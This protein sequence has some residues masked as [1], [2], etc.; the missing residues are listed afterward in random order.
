V[1]EAAYR[2]IR[3]YERRRGAIPGCVV[4]PELVA[5]ALG[6]SV[7]YFS[8]E[9]REDHRIPPDAIGALKPA[10]GLIFVR[11]RIA[12]PG[13]EQQ[14]IGEEL[15]HFVLHA[16][17]KHKP[18][19]LSLS[20]V[21]EEP[22]SGRAAFFCRTEDASFVDGQREPRWMSREAAF[23]AACL[24]MPRDRYEP[25][26]R[27]RLVEAVEQTISAGGGPWAKLDKRVQQAVIVLAEVRDLRGCDA[28]WGDDP[29]LLDDEDR[30]KRVLS[31]F[32]DLKVASALKALRTDH[33]RQVSDAAQR[34]R[35]AELGLTHDAADLFFEADG[36][37]AF[38][39]DKHYLVADVA[40][41]AAWRLRSAPSH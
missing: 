15:G 20:M 13:R 22:D 41:E 4:S 6:C 11:Q 10:Q 24:Q 40:V 2:L 23:F 14:T 27:Q 17:D 18:G 26:A 32:D 28:P 12:A 34:R 7:V 3:D 33:Q 29:N 8:D 25:V 31:L 35:S 39:R 21:M 38:R 30:C 1:E 5:S 19:Q 9:E 36:R 16:K 37:P